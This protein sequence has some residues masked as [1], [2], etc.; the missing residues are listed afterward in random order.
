MFM[1]M[2]I[3]FR[4]AWQFELHKRIPTEFCSQRDMGRYLGFQLGQ[5]LPLPV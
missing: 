2:N 1:P 5:A 3:A 4:V